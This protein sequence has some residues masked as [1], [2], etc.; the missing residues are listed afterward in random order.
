MIWQKA[1]CYVEI[2]IKV[3]LLIFTI[4]KA[5]GKGQ[6]IMSAITV[7]ARPLHLITPLC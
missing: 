5:L 2:C 6:L 7:K 3:N 1:V 4:Y